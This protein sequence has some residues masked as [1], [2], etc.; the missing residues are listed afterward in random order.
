MA[1]DT[2][3]GQWSAYR[4]WPPGNRVVTWPM[5]SRDPARSRLWPNTY[6]THYLGN[7]CSKWS[8]I[9]RVESTCAWWRHVSSLLI[10]NWLH[11]SRH[12]QNR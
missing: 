10:R 9:W 11:L 6:G 7:G 5:T 3:N 8:S 4:K 12:F 2:D 1:K